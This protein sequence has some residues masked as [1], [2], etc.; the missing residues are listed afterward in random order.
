MMKYWILFDALLFDANNANR[1]YPDMSGTGQIIE[2]IQV[3][4][5]IWY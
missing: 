4:A 1:L 2:V 5:A 3:I